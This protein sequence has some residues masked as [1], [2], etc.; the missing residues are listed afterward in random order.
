L[1]VLAEPFFSDRREWWP[2]G[3]P[4]Y[5]VSPCFHYHENTLGVQEVQGIEVSHRGQQ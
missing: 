1:Q 3:A 4:P 5:Y 2:T